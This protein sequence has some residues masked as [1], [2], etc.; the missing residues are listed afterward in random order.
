MANN[1]P[2]PIKTNPAATPIPDKSTVNAEGLQEMHIRDLVTSNAHDS[3][4]KPI[5]N[6]AHAP[7]CES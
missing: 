3:N 4:T 5:E 6:T 1:T 7:H 2:K